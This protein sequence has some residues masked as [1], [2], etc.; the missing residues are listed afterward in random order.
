[1]A[2]QLCKPERFS[3]SAC[4][5]YQVAWLAVQYLAEPGKSSEPDRTGMTVLQDRQVHDG[6]PGTVGQ[7]GQGHAA[8][9]QKLIEVYLDRVV[10]L[11]WVLRP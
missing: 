2:A 6:Y 5:S 8:V 1:M 10:W 11:R 4:V 7:L 3:L 9:S